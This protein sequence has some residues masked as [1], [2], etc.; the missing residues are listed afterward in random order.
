M[1]VDLIKGHRSR[2]FFSPFK[3]KNKDNLED[4][5]A[6]Y[7]DD[8]YS[9]IAQGWVDNKAP[10]AYGLLVFLFQISFLLLMI[11]SKMNR[12]M[13]ADEDND[14]PSTDGFAAFMPA[15]AALIVKTTQFLSIMAFLVFADESIKDVANAVRYFPLPVWSEKN[16]LNWF[17]DNIWT[18]LACV[19]RFTQGSFACFTVFLLVMT[20]TDVIEIVLNFTAVNEISNFDDSAFTLAISGKYG[21]VLKK[22][23]TDIK[24]KITLDYRCLDH[25]KDEKVSAAT[26]D[27][28]EEEELHDIVPA[29]MKDGLPAA[30][31]EPNVTFDMYAGDDEEG[32]EEGTQFDIK[33]KWYIPTVFFVACLVLGFS[34]YVSI[35]QS[36][37]EVWE[38]PQF[39]VE[40]DE[41]TGLL[42]YSGC[43]KNS[44]T[45]NDRRAIYK[46]QKSSAGFRYCKES[47][48]WVFY[49]DDNEDGDPCNETGDDSNKARARSSK[50]NS[51]D[52]STAFELNWVSMYNKPLEMYFHDI[53]NDLFCDQ[54]AN[55]GICDR[56]L[57]NY[58][59]QYD[60][61]DCCGTTCSKPDS[62]GKNTF[63]AFGETFNT[64]NGKNFT[65]D[66]IGYPSCSEP[67]KVHL[68]VD[69]PPFTGKPR[70]D[71]EE[72]IDFWSPR[73]KLEC[74]EE[75]SRTVFSIPVNESMFGK[76]Y[77]NITVESDSVCSLIASNFEPLYGS[78]NRNFAMDL[79][80]M[81]GTDTATVD[82]L[83][84]N[85]IPTNFNFSLLANRSSFV[86]GKWR[87]FLN[88][89]RTDDG[90]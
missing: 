20:S 73:L 22:K 4:E 28:K 31:V 54:F 52:V 69:L 85:S 38:A 47:R 27:G 42:D 37:P 51:F 26:K 15:N 74:G 77:S 25:L 36:L 18:A 39:R 16:L 86:F 13:S 78:L 75:E 41:E 17:K 9:F 45:Y 82:K 87:K 83:A 19:L 5:G 57:N 64:F 79:I 35:Q 59:F 68:T 10:L 12:K 6:K 88:D 50:T 11:C 40:F 62:C 2:P 63:Q 30:E 49:N 58:D 81:K 66:A 84:Q 56:D 46:S 71:L 21:D 67:G 34:S 65:N 89:S 44:N 29:A 80:T 7:P 48:R 76:S 3:F 53:N 60:G 90:R 33:Y 61:G 23:A 55:N 72:W 1:V 24:E 43:Y 8:C 14:N 70:D 32:N